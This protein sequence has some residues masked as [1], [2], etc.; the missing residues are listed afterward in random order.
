MEINVLASVQ[1]HLRHNWV[2]ERGH[3]SGKGIVIPAGGAKHFANVYLSLYTIR[4][5][6]KSE[7]PVVIFYNGASELHPLS[8]LIQV[9]V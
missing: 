2:A 4:V 1:A 8:T 7:L 3:R 5:L 6:L 9:K